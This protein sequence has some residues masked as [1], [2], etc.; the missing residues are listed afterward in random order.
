MSLRVFVVVD[1]EWKSNFS[2]DSQQGRLRWKGQ[3][4]LPSTRISRISA[5][6]FSIYYLKMWCIWALNLPRRISVCLSVKWMALCQLGLT[7]SAAV[8]TLKSEGQRGDVSIDTP[9]EITLSPPEIPGCM[10]DPIAGGWLPILG[11]GLR[12]AIKK[13]NVINF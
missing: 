2:G 1:T 5:P 7:L 13:A 11:W 9:L 4:L 6:L 12:V 3:P 8:S 10:S